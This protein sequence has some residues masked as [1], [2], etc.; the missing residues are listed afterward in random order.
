MRRATIRTTHGDDADAVA[1]SIRPDNTTEIDTTVEDGTVVTTVTRESTGGLHST[2][3]DYVVN[4]TVAAQL[5]TDTST[6][7]S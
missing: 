1:A 3:D 6:H 2:L 5:T 7:Q 4:L